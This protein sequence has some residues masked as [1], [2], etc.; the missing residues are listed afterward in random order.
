M[1]P[2]YP[3]NMVRLVPGLALP[4]Y[5]AFLLDYCEP[6][7]HTKKAVQ[8]G[9]LLKIDYHPSYLQLKCEDLEKVIEEAKRKGLR[10]Y[11][12]KHHV[13]ISNGI[14]SARIYLS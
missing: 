7:Y 2:K 5:M 13:T 9:H 4:E 1:K 12:G 3:V 8:A 6:T 11:R 10:V 14:Y